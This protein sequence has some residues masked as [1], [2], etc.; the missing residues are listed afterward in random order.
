MS[1]TEKYRNEIIRVNGYKIQFL[2]TFGQRT[3]NDE[4]R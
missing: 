1:R 4:E 2:M 3:K